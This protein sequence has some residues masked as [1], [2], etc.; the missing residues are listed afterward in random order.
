MVHCVFVWAAVSLL[1]RELSVPVTCK[2]R[3]FEDVAKTVSYA[4]MLVLAGC[5]VSWNTVCITRGVHKPREAG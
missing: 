2:I 3:V 4:Q 5:Q 1:H